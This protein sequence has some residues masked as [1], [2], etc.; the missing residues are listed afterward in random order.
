[1]SNIQNDNTQCHFQNLHFFCKF[2]FADTTV[3]N[4]LLWHNLTGKIMAFIF[5]LIKHETKH[6]YFNLD[7]AQWIEIHSAATFLYFEHWHF[8]EMFLTCL[9]LNTIWAVHYMISGIP[10]SELPFLK[11]HLEW[12]RFVCLAFSLSSLRAISG[13][14]RIAKYNPGFRIYKTKL[15]IMCRNDEL[16]ST[17]SWVGCLLH[18]CH[19]RRYYW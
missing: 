9:G 3:K 19:T 14:I 1:M 7:V 18:N 2:R 4:Y 10:N 6:E 11:N 8:Y 5:Q 16:S 15:T 17:M 12:V 13:P